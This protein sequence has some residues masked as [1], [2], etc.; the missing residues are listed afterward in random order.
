[1]SESRTLTTTRPLVVD[2]ELQIP[3]R[4]TYSTFD[5]SCCGFEVTS[6]PVRR[7]SGGCRRLPAA[8]PPLWSRELGAQRVPPRQPGY[9]L[10]Q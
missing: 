10:L 2:A 6:W 4:R 3:A 1:M 8:P 9:H 5:L 7:R